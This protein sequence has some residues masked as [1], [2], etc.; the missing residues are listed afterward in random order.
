MLKNMKLGTK[1]FAGFAL[2][3]ILLCLVAGVGFRGLL[4]VV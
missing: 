1:I 3:L 4:T 2:V